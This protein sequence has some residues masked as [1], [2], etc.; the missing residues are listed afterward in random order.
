[1]PNNRFYPTLLGMPHHRK[2]RYTPQF[3]IRHALRNRPLERFIFS[4]D[5][6]GPLIK[7][8][9]R[10]GLTAMV[11]PRFVAPYRWRLEHAPMPFPNLPPEFCGYKI[12][13]LTDLHAGSTRQ[14]YLLRVLKSAVATRPD[15]VV[16]S[17]D[18]LDYMPAGLA[19]LREL[20]PEITAPD[21]VLACFGNHDYH[22]YS[23][24]HVGK[25]SSHRAIHKRL[26]QLLS[27]LGIRYLCNQKID[28][29][30]GNATLQLV[31]I[32]EL[33]TGN[34]DPA[35]AFADVR[36]GQPCICLQHNPDGAAILKGYPWHWMLCGHTHGGQVI[37]PVLGPLFVPVENR[38]WLRG[39]YHFQHP[40]VGTQTMFIS[41]GSGSS[42]PVRLR[43][44]PEVRLF[45]L[46]SADR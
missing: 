36:T 12:L 13:H 14:S 27:T 38:Q 45:T 24:R 26:R 31:G 37:I 9:G 33:W 5:I 44:P 25:R 20:L 35:A 43:C 10:W 2:K 16:I 41:R 11:W 19:A 34:A 32:D 4:H 29:R 30:R 42:I 22:E 21:G 1:M 28:I 15:L 23:W 18:L 40:A 46:C 7:R 39:F 6:I 8:I 17:G 3:D